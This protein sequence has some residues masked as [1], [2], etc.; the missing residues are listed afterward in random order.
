MV[1][2]KAIVYELLHNQSDLIIW[3]PWSLNYGHLWHQ[4]LKWQFFK[5]E[6]MEKMSK[7]CNTTWNQ[8][9]SVKQSKQQLKPDQQNSNKKNAFENLQFV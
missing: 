5:V 4:P 7:C 1:T 8:E 3:R 2:V 9:D 6:D